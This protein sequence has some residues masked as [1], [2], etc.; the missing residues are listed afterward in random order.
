M[1][2]SSSSHEKATTSVLSNTNKNKLKPKD[3]IDESEKN[4]NS[5]MIKSR[6]STV[7]AA[8]N[9]L[10]KS[11]SHIT[12]MEDHQQDIE[13]ESINETLKGRKKTKVKVKAKSKD[14]VIKIE[15]QEKEE[16]SAKKTMLKDPVKKKSGTTLEDLMAQSHPKIKP[17]TE[18]KVPLAGPKTNS[19]INS[20]TNTNITTRRNSLGAAEFAKST[21]DELQE[22]SKS[23]HFQRGVKAKK[24]INRQSSDSDL[25]RKAKSKGQS[26]TT[27]RASSEDINTMSLDDYLP[28][29]NTTTTAS[30]L[31]DTQTVYTEPL[32]GT[33]GPSTRRVLR[34]R[35]RSSD[36]AST[37]M[38]C[39][40]SSVHSCRST[41]SKKKRSMSRT[42]A[43]GKKRGDSERKESKKFQTSSSSSMCSM[44][45][46]FASVASYTVDETLNKSLN[47]TLMNIKDNGASLREK[48]LE[49]RLQDEE[50]RNDILARKVSELEKKLI[51]LQAE[52]EV[53]HAKMRR[54]Q[55]DTDRLLAEKNKE[56]N[57][58]SDTVDRILEAE[59]KIDTPRGTLTSNETR[60]ENELMQAN[61]KVAKMEQSLSDLH[62]QN[63]QLNAEISCLRN[64]TSHNKPSAMKVVDQSLQKQIVELQE[65][66]KFKDETIE[67]LMDQLKQSKQSK[68]SVD[69]SV[70]SRIPDMDRSGHGLISSLADT[71]SKFSTRR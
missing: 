65:K 6:N 18:W 71:M 3:F 5:S 37:D 11:K 15:Q 39:A 22:K 42:S 26:Q 38:E 47:K 56:I 23:E 12:T 13:T 34:S 41:D 45:S 46:S 54:T 70:H 53:I 69:R 16:K 63:A 14:D 68:M 28:G 9:D 61:I 20:N 10:F 35:H 29:S 55:F 62:E 32:S 8:K 50:E 44:D 19:N 2:P 24:K 7:V 40:S 48:K 67:H 30:N 66:L 33:S 64:N 58:L 43:R 49:A 36:V 4:G 21:K 27:T 25:K 52:N 60:L 17:V 57:E 1:S 31:S 51:D 59:R